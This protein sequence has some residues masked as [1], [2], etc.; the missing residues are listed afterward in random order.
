MTPPPSTNNDV[1][2]FLSH[3]SVFFLAILRSA[4]QSTDVAEA[5][6]QQRRS[7]TPNYRSKQYTIMSKLAYTR[8]FAA[9]Q[10]NTTYCSTLSGDE[11]VQLPDVS[12]TGPADVAKGGEA[13]SSGGLS[14]K[15]TS[16][17]FFF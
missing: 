12:R 2:T 1:H 6:S 14:S 5:D 13:Q 16:T 17:I 4:N 10:S 7:E 3:S 9:E 8:T 15:F 11:S